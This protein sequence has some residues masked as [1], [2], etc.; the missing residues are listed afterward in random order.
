MVVR[1]VIRVL[2]N[3]GAKS[4]KASKVLFSSLIQGDVKVKP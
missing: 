3:V 1:Y 4:D 2:G